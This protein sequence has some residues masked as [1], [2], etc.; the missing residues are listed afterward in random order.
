[1][2]SL[3]SEIRKLVAV[4]IVDSNTL[5]FQDPTSKTLDKVEQALGKFAADDNNKLLP[6]LKKGLQCVAKFSA[7]DRWYRARVTKEF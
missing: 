7:D 3:G 4:E 1:M 5:Y 6:P 2:R